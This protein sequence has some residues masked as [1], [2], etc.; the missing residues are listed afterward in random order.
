M[1][2]YKITIAVLMIAT[3]LA[4]GRMDRAASVLTTREKSGVA[5]GEM[6]RQFPMVE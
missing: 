2:N 1:T 5:R 6:L 3:I 4:E